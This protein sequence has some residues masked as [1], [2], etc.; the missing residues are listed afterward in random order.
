MNK[1]DLYIFV[2]VDAAFFFEK[3]FDLRKAV[4]GSSGARFDDTGNPDVGLCFDEC[5]RQEDCREESDEDRV[6]SHG[7]ISRCF[8]LPNSLRDGVF[9]VLYDTILFTFEL[10]IRYIK[11]KVGSIY[12]TQ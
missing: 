3:G 6:V 12:H 5:S 2:E 4:Q 1:I 11:M 9:A 7:L 10:I 8:D